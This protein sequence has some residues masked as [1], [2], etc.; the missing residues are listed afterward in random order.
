MENDLEKFK[1]IVQEWLDLDKEI[2]G[3]QQE[4]KNKKQRFSKLSEYIITFMN[5]ENKQVCNIGE[6]GSLVLKS[7]NSTSSVKKEDILSLLV[8]LSDGNE[9]V[10][11]THLQKLYETR[12]QKT[13]TTLKLNT[14]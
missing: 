3:D 9:D 13:V 8:K 1:N 2:K 10:A 14:N 11:N 5:S 6:Y 4:L 12:K 7:R